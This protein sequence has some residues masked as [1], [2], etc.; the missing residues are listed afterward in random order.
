MPKTK[1]LPRQPNISKV[2]LLMTS[3][4]SSRISTSIQPISYL[5][6]LL[7]PYFDEFPEGE[8]S[9]DRNEREIYIIAAIFTVYS[10]LLYR[11]LIANF[12]IIIIIIEKIEEAVKE[13]ERKKNE[14]ATR[15]K[16]KTGYPYVFFIILNNKK[17]ES[18]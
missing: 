15:K 7:P 14:E 10:L 6:Y 16:K 1:L 18:R 17:N 8:G 3:T 12:R 4:S 11:I 2:F 5:P 9:R 13:K